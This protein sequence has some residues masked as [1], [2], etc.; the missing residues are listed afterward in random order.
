MLEIPMSDARTLRGDASGYSLKRLVNHA[1]KLALSF[2]LRILHVGS[3]MGFLGA[4]GGIFAMVAI[5]IGKYLF[6]SWA[7]DARGWALSIALTLILNGVIMFNVGI[8]LTYVTSI[9]RRSQGR[10]GFFSITRHGDG[11][12]LDTISSIRESVESRMFTEA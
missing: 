2:D 10:P 12:Y 3:Q 1:I 5:I 9:L 8:V 6:P 11:E 4:F 7:A